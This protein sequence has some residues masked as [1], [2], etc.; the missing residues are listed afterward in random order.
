MGFSDVESLV[1]FI[2]ILGG[3]VALV[4]ALLQ[5]IETYL[6]IGDKLRKRRQISM[7]KK[8]ASP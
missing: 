7:E 2:T 6:D 1:Q 4:L 8:S 3:A 5:I